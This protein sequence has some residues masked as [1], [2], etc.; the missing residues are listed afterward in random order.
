MNSA[1]S[2]EVFLYEHRFW[3]QVMGDHARFIHGALAPKE[4]ADIRTAS[5]FIEVFDELLGR[6]RQ[7]LSEREVQ[8][9]TREAILQVDA[10]RK[11]KLSLLERLLLRKVSIGLPPTFINHMVNELDEYA[12]ILGYLVSGK[13]PPDLHPVHHHLLWLQDAVGHAASIAAKLD[14]VEKDL[15]GKSKAFEGQ[16]ADFYLKSVELAGYLRTNLCEFPALSRFNQ[17]VNLEMLVFKQFLR[18]LEEM[19]LT[20]EMLGT[21]SPLMADHMAREECYYLQK[22]SEVSNVEAPACDPTKPRTEA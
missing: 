6:A 20:A 17:Q 19:G 11:F 2:R 21:L 16:F 3:L 8:A 7:E 22:L 18:E 1:A 5:L 12:R 10:L 9:L 13:Q 15:I 4:E 14:P